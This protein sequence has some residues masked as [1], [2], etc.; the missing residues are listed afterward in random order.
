MSTAGGDDLFM[1][2][3]AAVNIV[4]ERDT[5][6]SAAVTRGL[7]A[8]QWSVRVAAIGAV[9]KVMGPDVAKERARAALADPEVQVRIAAARALIALDSRDGAVEALAAALS[10]DSDSQRVQAAIELARIGDA[11]GTQTLADL[12]PQRGH[13][14]HGCPRSRPRR[15]GHR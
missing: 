15:R 14:P 3:R 2:I 6:A 1:A 9:A 10:V 4:G 11:R 5:E 13:P 8:D 12:A 7:G